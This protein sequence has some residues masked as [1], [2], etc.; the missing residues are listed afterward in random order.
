MKRSNLQETNQ[1]L[2]TPH[3]E[4][5]FKITIS[6]FWGVG[7]RFQGHF[8]FNFNNV[9]TSAIWRCRNFSCN[10]A[11]C[12]SSSACQVWCVHKVKPMVGWWYCRIPGIVNHQH[13]STNYSIGWK[14][15]ECGIFNTYH[16]YIKYIGLVIR[17]SPY[18]STEETIGVS[19]SPFQM[20]CKS[21]PLLTTRRTKCTPLQR[22]YLECFMW[23]ALE[24]C[25]FNEN[26]TIWSISLS[27]IQCQAG[28]Q[29]VSICRI[30]A[31]GTILEKTLKIWKKHRALHTTAKIQKCFN[32]SMPLPSIRIY[33]SMYWY[34]LPDVYH[35]NHPNVENTDTA[36]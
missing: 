11:F 14:V 33:L 22:R 23:R 16:I 20:V 1:V 28:K 17:R 9:G 36:Y 8:S 19:I 5:Q 29:H 4:T 18:Y 31:V 32:N 30:L 7:W 2:L 21:E 6:V 26:F 10:N 15:C 34:F 35:T 13:Q 3:F 25:V 12:L 27:Q 24:T